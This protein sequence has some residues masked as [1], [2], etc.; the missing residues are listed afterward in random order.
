M[1]N[2][3]HL[4][5][6][7]NIIYLHQISKDYIYLK[8]IISTT[9]LLTLM[10]DLIRSADA[11]WIS[12]MDSPAQA[13]DLRSACLVNLSCIAAVH[14]FE[15][16]TECGYHFMAKEYTEVSG[17]IRSRYEELMSLVLFTLDMLRLQ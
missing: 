2:A 3:S 8:R 15:N 5:L 12:P 10:M 16:E 17:L 14:L 13:K 6:I 11:P 4:D 9:L 1:S 7:N